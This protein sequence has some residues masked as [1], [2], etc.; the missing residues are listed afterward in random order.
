MKP[1]LATIPAHLRFLDEIAARW[2][3]GVDDDPERIGDGTLLL[4]GRRAA[5][6]LTEAFLRH[7]D[8]KAILLPRILPIGGLD[9][10]E[11]ALASPDALLLPP[12][13]P[14]M[15]RLAIL[16]RLVLQAETAFGT[17]PMLDQ[18]WPLARAL[19]DLMDEAERSGVDLAVALP[20]AVDEGF[21]THWQA[22]LRF[23]GII[24]AMWP[25]WLKEQGLINPVA[26]QIALLNAQA[27]YWSS[28]ADGNARLWAVGF[29][30]ALPAT[31]NALRGVLGHDHGMLILPGLDRDMDDDTFEALPDNHPQAGLSR[32]LASLD[33]R[34]GDVEL[35][36]SVLGEEMDRSVLARRTQAITRALLP[37][38]ALS[39]WAANPERMDCTGLYRLTSADQ[40]EEAAAI[41]L[42]LRAGIEQPGKRVALVTPDRALAGRVAAELAR[43]GIL[44]DDSAGELLITTPAGVLLRLLTQAVDQQLAPVAL[45]ALL[46]H[47]LVACGMT[48]GTCRASARLLERQL[49]RGPAPAPGIEG[50]RHHLTE[51]QKKDGASLDGASADKPDEPQSL[52]LFLTAI[53][54]CLAPAL[55]A[56]REER[57]LPDQLTALLTSA[58]A[59]TTTND[60]PGAERL[61]RGDDG[62]ALAHRFSDLLTATDV[63]PPQPWAVLDGLLAAVFTEERVQ[64]RRALRG[65]GD[66]TLTLHPRVFIWGLTEARLQTVDLM[67]LGGLVEGVWPPASDPGPW[68]SRPMRARVGLPSPEQAIGQAAHDFASCISSA[69]EIVLSTPGRREGAPAVPARW[70]VRL[71]A[72]LN[73]RGQK[74]VEHPAQSWL[75]QLDR[76]EGAATPVAP[77]EPRPPVSKRPRRLSVTEI[78]TW[79]RDPYAIYAR[80]VLQLRPLDPLEQSVDAS[81]YG[82]LVHGALDAWFRVHGTNWPAKAEASLRKAFLD[83]L[84]A[85]S[86]RPALA[87][88]WRPRLLRIA[89]WVAQAEGARR[90]ETAPVAILTEAK[91][92]ATVTDAPGGPFTLTGRADRID[93]FSEGGAA[94]LDYK[95]GS[96]P[97]TKDVL[98]G[99]SP[100][101]PLEAAM[102]TL[103]AFPETTKALPSDAKLEA[104]D[105]IYWRLTGG[106]EAGSETVVKSKGKEE[107]TIA[108]LATQAWE[109]LRERIHA[110][111]SKA[112]PYLSHPHPGQTPRFADYAQL[113]RV[114]EWSTAREDGAE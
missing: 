25:D 47:P 107:L 59:L 16:T 29:T 54:R 76:P 62:N 13:V 71:E 75:S 104:R 88:W 102:L 111:D 4:P 32:L 34:R 58:E 11:T 85:V 38:A 37:A 28:H 55:E 100:Q 27:S 94:L 86:L 92:R 67:V 70:L 53:E 69:T 57:T 97:S 73:G 22:T 68:L 84:E 78:E 65:H 42:I 20:D 106:A 21:A 18:A 1:A 64:G 12:A 90:K 66:T 24:T 91:G 112:Q 109:S 51:K 30:D 33:V 6:A 93:L 101:L 26:R 87:A 44:A 3:A 110:Y 81:D 52:D 98:A 23:L 99:W 10:A 89:D 48:P 80:H 61:W 79:I 5:R 39:D 40:Q 56:A 8:G 19:A 77:P 105:L 83:S 50:L 45:L 108:A 74:L 46:K 31:V 2:T 49:L 82:M 35:W 63:L 43:W 41:A 113:A 114:A 17:R 36:P 14:P 9:E 15:R 7:A 95:T 72:F 96:V 103:G 60:T